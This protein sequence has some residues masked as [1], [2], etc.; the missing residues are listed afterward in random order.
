M[1]QFKKVFVKKLLM[2]ELLLMSLCCTISMQAAL[3]ERGYAPSQANLGA[4]DVQPAPKKRRITRVDSI[5]FGGESNQEPSGSFFEGALERNYEL[6]GEAARPR[7]MRWRKQDGVPS[8][9]PL[10]SSEINYWAKRNKSLAR[11][12]IASTFNSDKYYS[13]KQAK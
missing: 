4:C 10:S 12:V 1:F 8:S 5:V 9:L 6:L 7:I 11:S 2:L 13:S 3:K